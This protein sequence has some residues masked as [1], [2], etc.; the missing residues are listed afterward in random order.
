MP[1]MRLQILSICL[2]YSIRSLDGGVATVLKDSSKAQRLQDDYY[3]NT[4]M[5]RL[6]FINLA[7]NCADSLFMEISISLDITTLKAP[8][9]IHKLG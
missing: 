1:D 5:Q 6:N 3:L 7:Q 8:E 9:F 2:E 4:K